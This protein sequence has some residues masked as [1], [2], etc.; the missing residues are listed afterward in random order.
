MLGISLLQGRLFDAGDR[1]GTPMV[2][3]INEEMA[4]QFWPS[5][6]AIGKRFKEML[7]GMDGNWATVIGVVKN[8][9]YNRD[10]VVIPTFY[11]SDG[12]RTLR[13]TI[14]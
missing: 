11:V 7:P 12:R 3:V 1:Q 13:S 2:A 14:W 4:R 8:V 10:G 6:T 5:E 9:I